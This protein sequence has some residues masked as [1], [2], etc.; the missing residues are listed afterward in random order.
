MDLNVLRHST[1]H[2]LAQAV[3]SLYPGV[4]LGIGPSI[5]NG[6]Y[7]DFDFKEPLRQDDLS[8]VEEKMKEII[9]KEYK[10]EREALS[11]EEAL[12]LFKGLKEAYKLEL[13]EELGDEE[14][15][16]YKNGDF[17]DLCKGPHLE[18]TGQ[19]KHFKLLSVAG[20][21]WR[22]NEKNAQL[23]RIYGTA[24]D[25]KSELKEHLKRVE[26]A[27]KRDHRKGASLGYFSMHQEVG[28]GLVVYHPKGALLRNIIEDYLK[29][30]HLARDYQ[31][32]LGPHIMKSDIWKTSGHYEFYRENMYFFEIDGQEYAVKPMNCPAHILVYAARI[33]SY[34][35]L[36]IRFFELG[37]VYR[38]EK[39]GVLH[40][41]MRARGFTQDDSHI[42][43]TKEHLRD[44][45]TGVIDFVKSTMKDFG[46]S[47]YEYELS[48]RPKEYI[49][50][51][52]DWEAAETA[53]KSSL[54]SEGE[55]YE[56]NE[57][58]GAFYGPKIDIK[59][60]DSLGRPWQCATIQ[61]DFALPER[62]NLAYIGSDGKKYRPV[63]L[64]R[65]I[66]GSLERFIGI[67]LEHYDF[68]L[69]VWLAPA[70]VRILAVTSRAEDYALSLKAELRGGL[71][72]DVDPRNETLG[73][74]IRRAQEEKIP[75][76]CIVGDKEKEARKVSVRKRGN[77]QLGVMTVEDFK[78]IVMEDIRNKS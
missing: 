4:K 14:I 55:K 71:R 65:V 38:H 54:D 10:F 29:K 78:K 37:T 40:G 21:Y 51:L 27:K 52:E 63:M 57:G 77:E 23:T 45:I 7:Y 64:H 9:K 28:P 20:A 32:V 74:K 25:T 1:S 36:P 44:E 76:M 42:F 30:E 58:E 49:G 13:I 18:S 17:V 6:F 68:A 47:Q 5:E 61:C 60:K 41:L 34:N 43:C 3:K 46:F 50:N 56:V 33:R 66:L 15:S 48:T 35:E 70:Q 11:K 75:Y 16:V 69:P 67:L 8:R 2:I 53:L 73:S 26:E 12:K 24:F 19:I 59:I 72:V 22:G 31:M 62:F 39:S